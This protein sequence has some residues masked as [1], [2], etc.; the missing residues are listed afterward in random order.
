MGNNFTEKRIRNILGIK[1]LGAV[2][3]T[4]GK[5]NRDFC[6][7]N[8]ISTSKGVEMAMEGKEKQ[9]LRRLKAGNR[10]AREVLYRQYVDRIWRYGYLRTHSREWASEISQETFLRAFKSISG[11]DGRASLGTWLY[12]VARSVAID[13]TRDRLGRKNTMS[14]SNVLKLVTAEKQS[15]VLE[16]QEKNQAIHRAIATLPGAQRDVIA[17]FELSSMSVKETAR[18]LGWSESRVKVT[19]HRARRNLRDSLLDLVGED[20]AKLSG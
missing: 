13:H 12:T 9:L 18:C 10:E 17:L 19:L 8:G 20:K 5:N 6:N 11:F 3:R 15:D 16:E 1:Q 2:A 14:D 4:V 7:Q